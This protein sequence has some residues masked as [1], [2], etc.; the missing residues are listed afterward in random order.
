MRFIDANARLT[1]SPLESKVD[2]YDNLVLDLTLTAQGPI[3][4]SADRLYRGLRARQ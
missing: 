2:R 4:Q 1:L 3:E